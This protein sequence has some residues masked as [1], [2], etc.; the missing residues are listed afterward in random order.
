MG[1]GKRKLLEDLSAHVGFVVQ[2]S[3][4]MEMMLSGSL[5]ALS[6]ESDKTLPEDDFYQEY[7]IFNRKTLGHLR[8][9]L[10][11]K[12]NFSDDEIEIFKRAV[13]ER[14]YIVHDIFTDEQQDLTSE[15]GC[16]IALERAKSA[17][18]HIN[19]AVQILDRVTKKLLSE[20]I[21]KSNP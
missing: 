12:L 13:N 2:A 7:E 18:E 6:N 11:K 17:M 8:N 20:E 14:N 19:G 1:I 4:Y 3:Q 9:E 5:T 15:I 16:T 10:K 21:K